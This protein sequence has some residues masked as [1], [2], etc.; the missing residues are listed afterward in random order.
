MFERKLFIPLSVFLVGIYSFFITT[1]QVYAVACGGACGGSRI[2]N[3]GYSCDGTC[4]HDYVDCPTNCGYAGG[5]KNKYPCGTHVCPAIPIPPRGTCD[6]SCGAPPTTLDDGACGTYECPGNPDSAP[7]AIPTGAVTYSPDPTCKDTYMATYSW[8]AVADSGCAGLNSTPYWAQGS[9]VSDFSSVL[10]GWTN[11]WVNS[12]N[13]TTTTAYSPGINLYFH[14]RSR[15]ALNNQSAWS[16]TDSVVIPTPSPY[17]TI[18]VSGP[19]SEDINGSCN[20]LSLVSSFTFNP[21]TV[22]ALGVTPICTNPSSSSYECDFIIDNQKGLCVSPNIEVTMGGT[23]SGYG[24]IGWRSGAGGGECSGYPV[25]RSYAVGESDT[26]IPLYFTYNS[27]LPTPIPTV[28]PG[29]P[30]VTPT[31]TTPPA[32]GWFKLKDT[33][34]NSRLSARQNYI[35]SNIQPYDSSDSTST[36]NIFIGTAGLLMQNSQL[37]PGANALDANGKPIYSQY[38][39]YTDGYSYIND[40]DYAKYIDYIKGRKTITSISML[41]EVSTGIYSITPDLDIVLDSTIFDSKKTV[42]VVEGD[43]NVVISSNFIPANGTVALVAKH[44]V[45]E[46]NVTEIKAILIGKTITTG[47]SVNALKIDGN[48]IDE[49]SLTLGRSRSDGSRPSLFVVFNVQMY[50]DLLPYLSTSTYDWKQIQ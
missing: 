6:M 19:L 18:H 20:P 4:Y 43:K 44:I 12:L 38:N 26:N 3:P 21:V 24:T 15:D 36:H 16:A 23:Y 8:N 41:S 39:W 28:T 29:G 40:V 31:P 9:S 37:E 14:V 1:P 11:T 17:P 5:N 46:P 22:P 27:I 13:Q 48:V 2:C 45:I 33:S 49:E 34:F 35:P 47:D 32:A 7:P 50:L 25:S 42:L 30:T 10:S